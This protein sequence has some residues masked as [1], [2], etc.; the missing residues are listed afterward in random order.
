MPH[1]ATMRAAVPS[2]S[3]RRRLDRWT[4]QDRADRSRDGQLRV[5]ARAGKASRSRA[6]VA[7]A[8]ARRVRWALTVVTSRGIG[9][10]GC[11]AG[12]AGG[13][14]LRERQQGEGGGG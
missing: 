5:V 10:E 9:G 6:L 7:R 13:G 11:G 3:G 2:P 4:C 1:R 8:A 12:S 14:A